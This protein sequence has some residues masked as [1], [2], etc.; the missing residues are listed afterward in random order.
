MAAAPAAPRIFVSYARSD[1]A[2]LVREIQHRLEKDHELPVWRD[3]AD[4]EGTDAWWPQVRDT[5]DQVE[6]LVLI[7]T[8]GAL[9]SEYV[10]R[11]WR[12]ARRVGTCVIPLQAEQGQSFEGLPRWMARHNFVAWWNKDSWRRLVR[13]LEGPCRATRVPFMAGDLPEDYVERP[14]EFDK[15]R[16]QLLDADRGQPIAVTTALKGAGGF[17]KTTL[18]KALC[19]D[20]AVRDAFADGILWVTLGQTPKEAKLVE[21]ISDLIEK[22]THKRPGFANLDA[23]ASEL[24]G[25]LA[26]RE[27]LIVIDDAWR[28]SD[29]EP[30]LQGGPDCARLI[31]TRMTDVLPRES[32]PVEVDAM[33]PNQA[34]ALLR[35][36]LPDGEDSALAGLAARLGKWP[37]MLKLA[38][39][40]LHLRVV[41]A[42]E[43]LAD[44]IVFA[45]EALD[46]VGLTAFDP[47]NTEQ[48]DQAAA[49][50]IAASLSLLG[51][52]ERARFEELGVFAENAQA[53]LDLVAA[54]WKGTGRL[55]HVQAERLW[56][57]LF[58]ASLILRLDLNAKRL[59]LHDVVRSYL[60]AVRKDQ[61]PFFHSAI[62]DA[63]KIR[64][65]DGWHSGPDDGYFFQYL[66]W[67][68]REAG[69]AEELKALLFD[70]RWLR[71][72]LGTVGLLGLIQDFEQLGTDQQAQKMA[73]GL[74]LSAHALAIDP[75]QLAGQLLGRFAAS[76]GTE[77]AKLLI[78]TRGGAGR[79]ILLPLRPTLSPPGTALIRL[80]SGHRGPVVALAVLPERGQA[81]SAGDDGTVR[82]WD[83]AS[84]RQ[85]AAFTGDAP[86][87]CCAVTPDGGFAAAGDGVG[88]IH[89]LEI[90]L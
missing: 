75:R 61:L 54:I 11:E 48:R 72:K 31:T 28:R 18:A 45:N 27:A 25:V 39:G 23:A 55:S 60:Q 10:R 52:N 76:D 14:D 53:P 6:H 78:D 36:D 9:R 43:S 1:G 24:A 86:L 50:S 3:L 79:P 73:A 80:F 88:Q 71:A 26:D 84:G 77:I 19:H 2:D 51:E 56:T 49:A 90:L 13:T 5:I 65:S 63:Y 33:Q 17:G 83:L 64:C 89:V 40:V 4:L 37:L 74:R 32:K 15:L 85:L 29:L 47:D 67:H 34:S 46:E 20:E 59:Q 66:P 38:N 58:Q 68:L 21:H 44:A 7:M 41:E 87:Y 62:V 8:E 81:L 82:L 42:G 30:F 16:A 12:Y 70:Y 69:Q 22:L 35:Y 57:R